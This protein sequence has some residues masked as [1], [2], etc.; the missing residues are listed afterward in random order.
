MKEPNTSLVPADQYVT[1][2]Y[3]QAWIC[4]DL[5]NGHYWNQNDPGKGYMWVFKTRQEALAHRRAQHKMKHGAQLS[6]PTKITYGR[7]NT[8]S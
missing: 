8:R 3:R 1:C 5:V 2:G 7:K 6:Y 4:F